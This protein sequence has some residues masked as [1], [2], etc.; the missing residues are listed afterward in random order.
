M[1]VGR[2]RTEEDGLM[3]ANT[4]S[5]M[6][7]LGPNV[8]TSICESGTRQLISRSTAILK[9]NAELVDSLPL[10]LAYPDLTPFN[11]LV[12][13]KWMYDGCSRLGRATHERLGYNLHFAQYL[14]GCMTLEGWQDYAVRETVETAFYS[15]FY[16][17][18]EAHRTVTSKEFSFQRSFRSH[19]NYRGL[20]AACGTICTG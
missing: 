9:R 18:V 13:T 11:Y 2:I 12:E 19:W 7:D 4:L 10:V 17:R 14:L 1:F 20:R 3:P 6:S 15:A 8:R 16:E 5:I